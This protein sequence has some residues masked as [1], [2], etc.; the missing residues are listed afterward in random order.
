[1]ITKLVQGF[2]V[3]MMEDHTPLSRLQPTAPLNNSKGMA[4][5]YTLTKKR[6]TGGEPSEDERFQHTWGWWRGGRCL[7]QGAEPRRGVSPVEPGDAQDSGCP[8]GEDHSPE[9]GG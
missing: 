1:M 7:V 4:K 8:Y 9:T 6:R 5:S 3:E 2:Q